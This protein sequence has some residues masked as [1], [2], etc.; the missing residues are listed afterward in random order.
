MPETFPFNLVRRYA[1]VIKFL[2]AGGTAFVLHISL[3]YLFTEV[4]G[5]Y[6]LLS[7]GMAFAISFGVS[8]SLQKF[9]TFKNNSMEHL[10]LQIPLYLGMQA[11][12]IVVNSILL[13]GLV[14]Y[15]HI[16]YV[17]AQ[18]CITIVLAIGIY[19][20]NKRFIFQDRAPRS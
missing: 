6:Y 20:L 12:N 9:W 5:V 8:F 15:F 11:G 3:L 13:Y 16:W 2:I 10:H 18:G 17:L 1:Q 7:N 14:E 19:F 4:F